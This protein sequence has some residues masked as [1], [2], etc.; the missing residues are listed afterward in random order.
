MVKSTIYIV[1]ERELMYTPK[2]YIWYLFYTKHCLY[3]P[4]TSEWVG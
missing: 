2:I 1:S 4:R 3:T